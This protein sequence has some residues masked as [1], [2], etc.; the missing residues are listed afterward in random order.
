MIENQDEINH[1]IYNKIENYNQKFE[2]FK[3]N[4][5][6]QDQKIKKQCSKTIKKKLKKNPKKFAQDFVNLAQY[7][8]DT[9]ENTEDSENET[10]KLFKGGMIDDDD[11]DGDIIRIEEISEED[12]TIYNYN[13]IITG[14]IIFI[15]LYL[16]IFFILYGLEV[17]DYYN[18]FIFTPLLFIMNL[19]KST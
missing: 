7:N 5:D 1:F 12:K 3:K 8:I 16:F 13:D 17:E 15:F 14:I 19:L 6:S 4:L 2:E 11:D 10:K 9:T 18:N